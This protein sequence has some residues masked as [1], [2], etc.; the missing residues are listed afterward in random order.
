[1][2]TFKQYIE[3]GYNFRLGGS[4]QKGFNQAKSFSELEDGDVF[5]SWNKDMGETAR[6]CYFS[7]KTEGR[8]YSNLYYNDGERHVIIAKKE[9]DNSFVLPSE[10]SIN[11]GIMWCI[12]TTFEELQ[13]VV[14]ETFKIDVKNFIHSK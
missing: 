11:T 10:V 13:E 9:L 6:G 4:Q 2:K 14:K 3:E 8:T 5:Y 7:Y 1:M 12:A